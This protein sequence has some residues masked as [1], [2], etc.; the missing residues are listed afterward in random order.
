MS[1]KKEASGT[2]ALV[3][4]GVYQ[5][6]RLPRDFRFEGD[7]VEIER[8]RNGVLLKPLAAVAI[9]KRRKTAKP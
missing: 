2:A 3:C 1:K 9:T 7:Q 6:V 5:Y 4:H 8:Y